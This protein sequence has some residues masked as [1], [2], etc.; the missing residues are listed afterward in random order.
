MSREARSSI[1]GDASPGIL[2][3][4]GTGNSDCDERLGR[5]RYFGHFRWMRHSDA[6]TVTP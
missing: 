3:P 1:W 6:L 5:I 2:D 4:R